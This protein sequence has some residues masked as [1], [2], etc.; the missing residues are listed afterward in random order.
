MR[1]TQGVIARKYGRTRA[2]AN[3]KLVPNLTIK[4]R[5]VTLGLNLKFYLDHNMR[6][7]KVHR[8]IMFTQSAWME[9]YIMMKTRMR[10]NASNDMQNDF[11]N[12]MNN[13]VYG[14][15]GENQRKRNDIH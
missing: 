2:Q 5:Y 3:V 8:V 13:A 4:T 6:F 12:L 15:T 9:P 1:D 7:T 14:T 11:P 10:M